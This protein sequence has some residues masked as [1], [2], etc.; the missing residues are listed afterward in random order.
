M[1]AL[2]VVVVIWVGHVLD[3][4]PGLFHK[5]QCR[6]HQIFLA[7]VKCLN[8]RHPLSEYCGLFEQM[9]VTHLPALNPFMTKI[10][11]Y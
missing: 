10:M 9:T 11:S 3:N 8:Q 1:F 6:K 7:H 2:R 4:S 5:L